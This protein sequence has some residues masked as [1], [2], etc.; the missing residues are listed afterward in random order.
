MKINDYE[1][2]HLARLY[3]SL[4]ECTVLLRNGGDFPLEKPCPLAAFGSG[5][6][7]TVKGGT[8]SGEVNSRTF[9]TV[10]EGLQKAGFTVTTGAWLDAYD[11]LADEAKKA[12]LA[13]LKA[14]ARA[15]HQNAIIYG[16]GKAMPAPEYELPLRA[17][18]NVAV[19][20]LSRISGEG[21]D[22]DPVPGDILLTESERR[23][24]L[25]LNRMY[26]KFMLVLNTGGPVDLSG[27]DE[28]RNILL[29]SQL[30]VQ[31]G[32]V[33]ADIL[34]GRQNPSGKLTTTWA[35]WEEYP[36]LIDFGDPDDTYYREGIY[37]G[38]RWFDSVGKRPLFPFGHGLSYTEFSVKPE[39]VSA[40]GSGI[41]LRAEVENTGRFTGK[42]VV[43]V[44]LS[45]P[46]GRLDQPYQSLAG[47]ARTAQLAPGE[48]ESVEVR[49]DLRD[50]A[51]YDTQ[52][53]RYLLEA[54][55]YVLRLGTSSADTLP[56]AVIRL[57]EDVT[58]LQAG[59]CFGEPGFADW[60][61]G[62]ESGEKTGDEPRCGD[63][64]E[65]A[66]AEVLPAD[67]PVI[68]LHASDF[69]PRTMHRGCPDE[70]EESLRE[71]TD[72]QLA[73]ISV[74]GFREKGGLLRFVGDSSVHVAGAAG[75]TASKAQ[76][77]GFEPL[78][79]ADGPAGLRLTPEFYR[80]GQGNA[81]SVGQ[82]ALPESILEFL[83]R[84][85]RGLLQRLGGR[86]PKKAAVETQYCTA[87][88]I[89]TALAQSWDETLAET[90]GDIVGEEM[91]RFGVQ[92]WLAPALNIH[93]SIRC[94]RNFEYFSEDPLISG[95]MAA[96]LTKG[97]QRHPGCGTTIKHF[98]ANNQETNRY[99]SNSRVSERAL[100]EIYLKGF[101]ICVREAQPCAVMTSYNLLNGRHTAERRDLYEF[102]REEYGFEG[103]VMTDWVLGNG[104]MNRKADVYP[105]VQPA[106][107]A[108]AGGD[109]FMPGCRA[110]WKDML[111]GLRDGRLTREQL[112][113][114]ASRMLR[115]VRKLKI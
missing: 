77:F 4:A 82:P 80:D 35:A 88:P 25:A 51:S 39:A 59:P 90:C 30:G 61:P 45:A 21:N 84:P 60:K 110:D 113:A 105:R 24:I 57:A 107:V 8:G 102:L 38:Y 63:G 70:I 3:G 34:L 5:V 108:A 18:G 94:G 106:Q 22:R 81:H 73:Y 64:S 100:R 72:E 76:E 44:Y 71:M 75:E 62:Q 6:R 65:T 55:Q 66:P 10:E 36:D 33:L 40:C 68:F 46:A 54:G 111:A 20:V 13:Q 17:A 79:M 49:F 32:D 112:L 86:T 58:V 43:Q 85:A 9:V 101:A 2:E 31:T 98:A 53:A 19:Y 87:I 42:E 48:K 96:A 1:K 69:T 41:T 15:H 103:I 28:V 16:M 115:T 29:L 91:E 67:L 93:R 89:G 26:G 83:P 12:F 92:L 114:N 11:A 104:L 23:D 50:C 52:Q 95:K 78:I 74:G 99:G 109:V 7:R 97:V 37:V 27:L 47:F 14:E 56:A